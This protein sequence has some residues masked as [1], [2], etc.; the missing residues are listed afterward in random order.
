M[1]PVTVTVQLATADAD[2]IAQAQAPAGAGNF[3]LN[4]AL[5]SGGVAIL[6]SSGAGRQVLVTTAA[7]ESGD[8]YTIYGT[9]P[10][11]QAISEQMT[12]PN[13]TTGVTTQFFQTVT[14]VSTSGAATGNVTIG[15]NGVGG[16]RII[17]LDQWAAGTGVQVDVLGTANFTV[18]STYDNLL[19]ISPELVTWINYPAAALA[20]ATASAQGSYSPSPAYL[21]LQVN[22]GTDPLIMNVRQSLY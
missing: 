16:S 20:A 11:G 17:A 3:T 10:N 6:T 13:N 9:D 12:G 1:L 8:T 18:Q 22:S 19:D 15:T 21:R 5:V 2:G 4:G 7:D 14:R